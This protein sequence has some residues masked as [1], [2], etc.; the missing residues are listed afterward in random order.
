MPTEK[1]AP[2]KWEETIA[3]DKLGVVLSSVCFIHCLALPLMT[4]GSP[5]VK[6]LIDQELFHGLMLFLLL[7]LT[8]FTFIHGYRVHKSTRV[9][10]AG[11]IG[12][13]LLTTGLLSHD[14]ETSGSLIGTI[15]TILGGV[16]LIS[17]HIFNIKNCRCHS[18]K[19]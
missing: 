9:L 17:G 7:P 11:L 10:L 19:H 14:H 18:H 13:T 15:L 3:F 1:T 8:L 5:F 4:F 2:F 16:S 12:L 6:S